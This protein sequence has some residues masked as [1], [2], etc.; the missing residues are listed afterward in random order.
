MNNLI[1]DK[2][3]SQ[4]TAIT[5]SPKLRGTK[6]MIINGREEERPEQNKFA[7]KEVLRGKVDRRGETCNREV[8]K[9]GKGKRKR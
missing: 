3:K 9:R 2:K 8:K 5:K 6:R 7:R 4:G 1:S